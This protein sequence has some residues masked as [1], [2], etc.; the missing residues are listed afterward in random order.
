MDTQRSDTR[1]TQEN[2]DEESGDTRPMGPLSGK[3]R[4]PIAFLMGLF[5]LIQL[6]L[7][8]CCFILSFSKNGK[9]I[10]NELNPPNLILKPG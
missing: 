10:I 7:S 3:P 9:D 8:F 4:L 5:S 1:A 6:S 2:F